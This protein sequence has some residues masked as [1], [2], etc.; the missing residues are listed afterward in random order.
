MRVER[1][2]FG[3]I[4]GYRT[5]AHSDGL[6]PADCK[7]LEGFAFGTSYDPTIRAT[8]AKQ[9][10]YWSRPLAHG[11]RAFTLVRPGDADDAGR[12]T[13]LFATC[14]ISVNDWNDV[15]QGD[16]TP[17]LGLGD[18]WHWKRG[19]RVAAVDAAIE[20]P[21]ELKFDAT[22]MQAVLGIVSLV[23]VSFGTGRTTVIREGDC[24]LEQFVAVERLLPPEVRER[25]STVHRGL[26]GDMPVTI[27]CLAQSVPAPTSNLIRKPVGASS[28]YARRLVEAG[29]LAGRD[30]GIIVRTYNRFAQTVVETNA[31]AGEEGSMRNSETGDG[32]DAGRRSG[33]LAIVVAAVAFVA[34]GATGWSMH[35]PPPPPPPSPWA[36]IARATLEVPLGVGQA[37]IDSLQVLSTMGNGESAEFDEWRNMVGRKVEFAK[38][39][40]QADEAI[41][42]ID[43]SNAESVTR[44]KQAIESL[45]ELDATL[46]AVTEARMT[47]RRDLL[48]DATLRLGNA[49]SALAPSSARDAGTDAEKLSSDEVERAWC[50]KQSLERLR[51]QDRRLNTPAVEAAIAVLGRVPPPTRRAEPRESPVAAHEQA[52]SNLKQVFDMVNKALDAADVDSSKFNIAKY[53]PIAT[54]LDAAADRARKTKFDGDF[55]ASFAFGRLAEIIRQLKIRVI[56]TI[57]TSVPAGAPLSETVNRS[58]TCLEGLQKQLEKEGNAKSEA[59]MQ[60]QGTLEALKKFQNEME[61]KD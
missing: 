37:R 32:G 51:D 17:L 58:I 11:R 15:L 22:R 16:P 54:A 31:G 40:M 24:D 18:L 56:Q 34:G 29:A 59:H 38:L 8:L 41:S 7:A 57:P 13:L 6:S 4:N 9:P 33:A 1:H 19:E 36:E 21:S 26:N 55:K 50:L 3:S 5:L 44:A 45:R 47:E 43:P 35:R 48:E 61:R 30:P 46:Y 42:L 52:I 25:V 53:D 20:G 60:V 49:A 2:I 12:P 10:A 14:V 23:E 39:A 28:P 27:N